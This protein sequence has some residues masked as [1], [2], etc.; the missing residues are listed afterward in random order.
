VF[1]ELFVKV[2][3]SNIL[4]FAGRSGYRNPHKAGAHIFISGTQ[5]QVRVWFI[6]E[7]Y[8]AIE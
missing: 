8:Y 7:I 1:F 5:R 6:F 4:R 3:Y 2:I